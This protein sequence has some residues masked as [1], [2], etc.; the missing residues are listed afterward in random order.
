MRTWALVLLA[1]TA[2]AAPGVSLVSFARYGNAVELRLTRG[3][4]EVEWVSP[5][6]FRFRRWWGS[7]LQLPEAARREPVSFTIKDAGPVLE[8]SSDDLILTI[9][10]AGLLVSVKGIEGVPLMADA[11]EIMPV[12]GGFRWERQAPPGARYFGLGPRP[13]DELDARGSRIVTTYPFLICSRGY[14]EQH[15]GQGEFAF[16]L[17]RLH[18]ERYSIEARGV[19]HIDYYFYFGPAI[20]DIFEQRLAV[21]GPPPRLTPADLGLLKWAPPEMADDAKAGPAPASWSDLHRALIGLVQSS[22][23]GTLLA[24]FDMTPFLEAPAALRARAEELAALAPVLRG[25]P[26]SALR[27]QLVPFFLTYGEEARE[28]GYPVIHPLPFQ[29]PSDQTAGRHADQF[30]LGDELLAA[31]VSS[32]AGERDVYLPQG[33]WTN[34]ATDETFAGRRTVRIHRGAGNPP[35]FARNGTILPLAS[36]AGS[37]PMMLH[38][39]PRL[40]AEFFIFESDLEDFSQVHAA[41]AGD[42]MRLEIE[43]KKTREYEWVVHHVD[44]PAAVSAGNWHYEEAKKCLRVR[45]TAGAGED[46]IVNISF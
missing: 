35:L 15:V 5:S 14:A 22:L 8:F 46:V 34:L 11:T 31:P 13:A 36:P 38:Y 18:P 2:Q 9:R 29:F 21:T 20:K 17:A 37:G 33:V 4:A 23:S 6:T 42:Y 7:R 43:S 1:A 26:A 3:S 41:P 27:R 32:P 24:Q 28:R 12:E 19:D 45:L 40:G 10:K 25:A 44:R 30:M 16:D 39:F